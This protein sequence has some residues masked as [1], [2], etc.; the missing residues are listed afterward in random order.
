M[1]SRLR[2]NRSRVRVVLQDKYVSICQPLRVSGGDFFCG[3]RRDGTLAC[4]TGCV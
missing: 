3:V 2:F 1:K 4:P